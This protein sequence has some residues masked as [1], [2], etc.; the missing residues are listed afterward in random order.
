MPS[1]R[2]DAT[3]VIFVQRSARSVSST[4]LRCLAG[5]EVLSGSDRRPAADGDH[6][7]VGIV[8]S[9]VCRVVCWSSVARDRPMRERLVAAIRIVMRR[10]RVSIKQCSTA[11][12]GEA[13]AA[14]THKSAARTAAVGGRSSDWYSRVP[15]FYRGARPAKSCSM[16]VR[17]RVV[18]RHVAPSTNVC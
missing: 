15:E 10:I 16:D 11:A 8:S 17:A 13:A 2:R 6:Q 14:A 5:L 9:C 18:V 3:A 4:S 7:V 1:S 12:A